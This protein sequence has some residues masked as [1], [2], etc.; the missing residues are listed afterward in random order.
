MN[1][2]TRG[3]DISGSQAAVIIGF[4]AVVIIAAGSWYLQTNKDRPW[5]TDKTVAAVAVGLGVFMVV[6][7]LV[8]MVFFRK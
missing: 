7:I 1:I 6:G 3:V 8:V 4:I 5:A 2:T